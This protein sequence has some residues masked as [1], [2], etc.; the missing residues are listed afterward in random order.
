MQLEE[1][2][3]FHSFRNFKLICN[4]YRRL[5]ELRESLNVL[6][7]INFHLNICMNIQFHRYIHLKYQFVCKL[8]KK[9]LWKIWTDLDLK[10]GCIKKDEEGIMNWW[11]CKFMS[12]WLQV[13]IKDHRSLQSMESEQWRH[14]RRKWWWKFWLFIYFNNGK[15]FSSM[16]FFLLSVLEECCCLL[17]ITRIRLRINF[18][19]IYFIEQ[20][21]DN[22]PCYQMRRSFPQWS[23][24][25]FSFEECFSWYTM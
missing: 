18:I 12:K 16:R 1:I 24:W 6:S 5:F 7:D 8:M 20:D 3:W 13:N 2:T 14:I 23:F 21:K 17:E 22:T 10:V 15:F 4:L 25:M 9:S 19:L 11:Y